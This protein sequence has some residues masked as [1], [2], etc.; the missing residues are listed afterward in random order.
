MMLVFNQGVHK[1]FFESIQ[2]RAPEPGG[3]ANFLLLC[4]LPSNFHTMLVFNQGVHKFFFELIQKRAPEPGGEGKFFT[5]GPIAMKLSHDV[6]IQP[7][8]A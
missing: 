8:C 5:T 2:K 6:G 4:R 1:F 3:G 7:E